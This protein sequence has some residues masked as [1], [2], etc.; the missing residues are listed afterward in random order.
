MQGEACDIIHSV[1]FWELTKGEW[2]S[3]GMLGHQLAHDLKIPIR[4][5][6]DWDADE[7]MHDHRLWDPAHWEL[8]LQGRYQKS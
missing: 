8:D 1:K 5:G 7:D 3:I 6:G 4:W 2:A